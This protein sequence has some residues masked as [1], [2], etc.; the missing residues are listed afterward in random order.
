MI[1]CGGSAAPRRERS[2]HPEAVFG[3]GDAADSLFAKRQKAAKQESAGWNRWWLAP[4][5]IK[6]AS[7]RCEAW[8]FCLS[9]AEMHEAAV[10]RFLAAELV[11]LRR[12]VEG[13]GCEEA[14]GEQSRVYAG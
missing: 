11:S 4:D 3:F 12:D 2:F 6:P 13:V 10:L 7:G 9:R 5:G 8:R 1:D 14:F